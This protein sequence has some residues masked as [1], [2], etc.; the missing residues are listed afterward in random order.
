MIKCISMHALP[1]C[2]SMHCKKNLILMTLSKLC[3]SHEFVHATEP[4][5]TQSD[6]I[7]Q[8]TGHF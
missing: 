3:N 8:S 6:G 5:I 7:V 2:K 4:Y 1:A